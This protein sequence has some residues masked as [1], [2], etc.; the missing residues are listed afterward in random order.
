MQPISSKSQKGFNLI[1]SMVATLVISVGLL[2]VVGMQMLAMKGTGN[3]FHQGQASTFV[4]SLFEKMRSNPQ[5]VIDGHYIANSN[6]P[7]QFSCGPLAMNC[8]DGSTECNAKELA[9]SDLYFSVCGYG[10]NKSGSIRKVLLNG[11]FEITCTTGS[12]EDQISFTL[13]WD[14]HALGDDGDLVP[15]QISL[16]TV[17]GR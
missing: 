15:R 12:C 16:D 17:I 5:G 2:G 3:A 7:A 11:S 9:Q 1:E 4:K 10:D 8:E 14:E 6:D 13:K